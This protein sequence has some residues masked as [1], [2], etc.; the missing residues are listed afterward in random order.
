MQNR[1]VCAFRMRLIRHGYE[2]VHLKKIK[3]DNAP[4][5][6]LVEVIEP[7][8]GSKLSSELTLVDMY[9]IRIK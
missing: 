9:N 4:E 7:L 5:R 2:D 1:V 8:F 6:Y 3:N